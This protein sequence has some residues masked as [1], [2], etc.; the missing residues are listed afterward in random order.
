MKR[1][2]VISIETLMPRYDFWISRSGFDQADAEGS[3]WADDAA[4]RAHARQ[5]ISELKA[6]G[7]YNAPTCL[8]TVAVANGGPLV[9]LIPF[10]DAQH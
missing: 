9:G 2:L 10:E 5:I 4:A 7:D 6:S 8:V 1:R 3:S